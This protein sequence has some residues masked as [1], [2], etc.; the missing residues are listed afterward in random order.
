MKNGIIERSGALQLDQ[1]EGHSL[2]VKNHTI[3]IISTSYVTE[4]TVSYFVGPLRFHLWTTFG[5]LQC[6]F[7]KI[8]EFGSIKQSTSSGPTDFCADLDERL[9][10]DQPKCLPGQ[11][12]AA[13]KN[14]H[15]S[16]TFRDAVFQDEKPK[17]DKNVSKIRHPCSLYWAYF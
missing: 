15:C 7:Q 14:P 13:D 5:P 17:C 4:R 1:I 16:L 12:W 11:V 8:S 10:P 2:L 3:K 6:F 9:S